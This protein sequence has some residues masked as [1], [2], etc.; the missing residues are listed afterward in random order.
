MS[1]IHYLWLRRMHLVRQSLLNAGSSRTV[2]E[3]AAE[4]GF[5]EL[6]RFSV[7][8]RALFGESPFICFGSLTAAG[9]P[10]CR[11]IPRMRRLSEPP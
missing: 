2:T 5:L 4:Y 11:R 10:G 1:P 6:G 9:S 3:I 7:G 8:Y